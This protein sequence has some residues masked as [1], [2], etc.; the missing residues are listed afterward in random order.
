MIAIMKRK[1]WLTLIC[2]ILVVAACSDDEFD[3][4]QQL[5]NEVATIDN[6]L[7]ANN[8]SAI[9]DVTGVRLVVTDTGSNLPAS[10][11]ANSTVEI[12]Y[13]G[14]LFSDGTKFDEGTINDVIGDYID[15]WQI[16]FAKLPAGS[17]AK[18][19]IPSGYAYGQNPNGS[20]PANSTLV[21]DVDFKRVILTSTQASKFTADTTA[22]RTYLNEKSI[23]TED[24]LG[25]HYVITQPGTGRAPGFYDKVHVKY[26][27]RLLS[28]DTKSIGPFE[29]KPTPQ[30]YSMVADYLPGMGVGLQQMTE[31]AKATFYF[32]SLHGFAANSIQGATQEQNIP[33][34]S[35]LIVEM[36]LID[37]VEE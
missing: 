23:V 10:I 8:I 31:G 19:Y 37:I 9:K 4:M 11:Y 28:D 32:P 25:V 12:Q 24:T 6:Y 33:A 2:I 13:T 5:R 18:I 22:I 3:P 1:V 30:F 34:N 29:F 26:T 7:A 15:G 16:A 27:F 20:I 36:E 21:F 17:K 35:N 14:T